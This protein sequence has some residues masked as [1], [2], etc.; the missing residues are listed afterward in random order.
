MRFCFADLI[1]VVLDVVVDDVDIKSLVTYYS[2]QVVYKYVTVSRY[3]ECVS[4]R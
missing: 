4:E 2:S 1:G 3:S